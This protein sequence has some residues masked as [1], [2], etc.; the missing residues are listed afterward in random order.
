M[1]NKKNEYQSSLKFSAVY[2]PFLMK[3]CC[4]H[5]TDVHLFICWNNF[6]PY[7]MSFFSVRNGFI[8]FLNIFSVYSNDYQFGFC[9]D[10][11][12]WPRGVRLRVGE[13]EGHQR[14]RGYMYTHSWF[15]LLYS[16]Q[17]CKAVILQFRKINSSW[18]TGNSPNL[19][20]PAQISVKWISC[21]VW[22]TVLIVIQ[23]CWYGFFT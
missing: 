2:L 10:A 22:K 20:P 15:T 11:L 14:G 7:K 4:H 18:G 16:S 6:I 23:L 12:W 5:H 1:L 8:W 19:S 9:N 3:H 17:R 21:S 13:V